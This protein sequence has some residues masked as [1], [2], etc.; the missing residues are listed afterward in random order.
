LVIT[1]LN[2]MVTSLMMA[3]YKKTNIILILLANGV[4]FVRNL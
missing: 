1:E 3:D 4:R 2:D